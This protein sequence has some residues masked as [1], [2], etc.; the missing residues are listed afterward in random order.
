MGRWVSGKKLH[1]HDYPK[2]GEDSR[3]GKFWECQCGEVFRVMEEEYAGS[4][5][6]AGTDSWWVD[7][8]NYTRW[9]QV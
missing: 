1:I 8:Y 5:Q 9:E 2:K 6:Y 7:S 3:K 4:K